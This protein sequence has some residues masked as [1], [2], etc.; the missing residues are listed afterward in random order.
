MNQKILLKWFLIVGG[1]L[2]IVIGSFLMV[3]HP[4][5]RE[6]GISTVPIFNQMAG[7]F[8]LGF[9]ILLVFS[10]TAIEAFRIIPLVNILLRVIMI[11]FSIFQLPQFPSFLVILIPAMIYDIL[12]SIIV[13]I[14]LKNLGLLKLRIS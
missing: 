13:L 10:S 5:L 14:L 1:V 6:F 12:W 3:F 2:E 11:A 4:F 8:L 9:G 7:T